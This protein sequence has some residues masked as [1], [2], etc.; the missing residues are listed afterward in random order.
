MTDDSEAQRQALTV[1]WPKSFNLLCVFHVLQ[2]FW[3]WV[4]ERKNNMRKEHHQ[5]LMGK[6][7]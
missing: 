5:P 6:M 2:S 1:T 3:I 4:I 7:K